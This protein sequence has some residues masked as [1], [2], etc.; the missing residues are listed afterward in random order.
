MKNRSKELLI[1][2]E[3]VVVTALDSAWLQQ[4]NWHVTRN[5]YAIRN[6]TR[7]DPP[8]EKRISMH[9]A[10]LHRKRIKPVPTGYVVD[11]I[12][13]DGLDNR[14]ENLRFTTPAQKHRSVCKHVIRTNYA[15]VYFFEQTG[16]YQAYI[17]V[18][19]DRYHLGYYADA[20]TAAAVYDAAARRFHGVFARL[21]RP[22]L[23]ENNQQDAETLLVTRLNCLSMPLTVHSDTKSPALP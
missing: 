18:A 15:G 4:W 16:R 3:S 23:P 7:D 6:R 8:G 5:G 22:A 2:N 10:I 20:E 14:R 11:H 1:N 21:N 19:G 9:R 13:G 17:T 12:N